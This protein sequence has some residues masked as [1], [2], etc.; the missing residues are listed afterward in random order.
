MICRWLCAT[1]TTGGSDRH[2][3]I[4]K[5]VSPIRLVLLLH[6]LH[7]VSQRRRQ[8]SGARPFP[9]RE[10]KHK[11]CIRVKH[12]EVAA[13]NLGHTLDQDCP[14]S[15]D[16]MGSDEDVDAPEADHGFSERLSANTQMLIPNEW[17]RTKHAMHSPKR[18]SKGGVSCAKRCERRGVGPPCRREAEE[19]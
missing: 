10:R 15:I 17:P 16:P 3:A 11:Q 1:K 6:V 13:K 2:V 8:R 7:E 14:G 18:D 5:F 19:S 4:V 9:R 12:N